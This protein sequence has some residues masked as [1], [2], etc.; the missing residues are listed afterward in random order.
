MH[1]FPAKNIYGSGERRGYR[2]HENGEAPVLQFFNDEGGARASSISARRAS[3]HSPHPF[4]QSL[5]QTPNQCL[6]W[7]P[8]ERDFSIRSR[9]GVRIAPPMR[10]RQSTRKVKKGDFR[11]EAITGVTWRMDA[12]T[13]TVCMASSAGK[14][15]R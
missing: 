14:T 12:P 6:A 1:P 15:A 4:R 2:W 13:T 7:H 5:D 8:F 9:I 10:N 3:T 11:R